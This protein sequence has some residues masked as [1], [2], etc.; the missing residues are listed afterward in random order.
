[1][2]RSAVKR[3]GRITAAVFAVM[4]VFAVMQSLCLTA[5][6][7]DGYHYVRGNNIDFYLPDGWTVEETDPSESEGSDFEH[8]SR[9]YD[10][11]VDFDLYY[12]LGS[13]DE[14][15]YF[16]DDAAEYYDSQGHTVIEDLYGE[17]YPQTGVSFGEMQIFQGTWDTY[18]VVDATAGSDE[19]VV[20]LNTNSSLYYDSEAD[21]VPLVDRI[22]VFSSHE[23]S[24]LSAAEIRAISDPIVAEVYDFGYDEDLMGGG[25]EQEYDPASGDDSDEDIGYSIGY[26]IGQI[27]TS[28][29]PII[30]TIII[31]VVIRKKVRRA[32][33]NARGF[34]GRIDGSRNKKKDINR[35]KQEKDR[36]RSED[37]ETA[38]S[39]KHSA[40]SSDNRYVRSLETL[41]KS[42][43]V[44]RSEMQELLSKYERNMHELERR[45]RRK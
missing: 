12:H 31:F 9:A 30:V 3:I 45:R 41:R 11:S 20:Y 23:G 44:T 18:V 33:Q 15:I 16:S 34:S 24:D 42:G 8:I 10:A 36:H 2:E 14:S 40:V 1:M 22:L 19:Q 35:K 6:Y 17:L 7:A 26:H 27:L 4:I 21:S 28:I 29:A 37:R 39:V 38:V 32:R 25:E 43:L 5:V 13:S